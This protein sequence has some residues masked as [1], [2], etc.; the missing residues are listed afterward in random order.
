MTTRGFA[1]LRN[2][3]RENICLLW[4]HSLVRMGQQRNETRSNMYDVPNKSHAMLDGYDPCHGS[5]H[6]KDSRPRRAS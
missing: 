6:W 3:H 4:S 2:T 1:V 5:M